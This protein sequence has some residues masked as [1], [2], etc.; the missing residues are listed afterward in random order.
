[1][2]RR[3]LAFDNS[4]EWLHLGVSAGG[5]RYTRSIAAGASA[6]AQL[7]PA[8]LELLAMAGLAL[9][10]VDAV[11]FGRGP[12]AFTGLRIACSVAQGIALGLAALV[13]PI[14]SLMIVAEDAAPGACGDDIW[15][16]MDARMQEVYLACYRR[17][18]LRD[19]DNPPRWQ[20]VRAPALIGLAALQDLWRAQPPQR[21]AGSALDAF[22][23]RLD[24]GCALRQGAPQDRAAA[25]LRLAEAA[26]ADDAGLD[27]ALALPVYV[28][29]KVALTT[30]ERQA[31]RSLG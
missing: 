14:D 15:V 3:I 5:R 16:A 24:T 6:S 28:R 2:Q 19:G 20:T 23:Q 29:D 26:L 17:M 31:Q 27:A 22:A 13:L 4:T 9:R 21:V 25:L 10:N 30:A 18:A 12:G 1:M 8:A 11:A 7:I